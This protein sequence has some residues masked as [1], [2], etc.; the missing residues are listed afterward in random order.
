MNNRASHPEHFFAAV[1]HGLALLVAGAPP[2]LLSV[3][4]RGSARRG[5]TDAASGYDHA[6]LMSLVHTP[7]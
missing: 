7:T 2:A 6:R 4:S 3:M 5:L 1:E